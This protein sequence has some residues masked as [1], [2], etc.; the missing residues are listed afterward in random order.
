MQVATADMELRGSG[1]LLG[2]S[3]HGQIDAVGLDTYIELL[4]EAVGQARG[5][6]SRE[7][8]DPEVELPVKAIIPED[9]IDEIPARLGAYRELGACRTVD[10]VRHLID[11]WEAEWGEPPPEVLNLGWSAEARIRCRSLG[12]ERVTWMRVRVMLDFHPTTQ[13][14][15]S[16]VAALITRQPSRFSMS[17]AAHRTVRDAEPGHRLAVRFSPEEGQ[18]PYRFLHWVFR[19]LERE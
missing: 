9:Y 15:P 5:E 10:Q 18:T 19:Q 12:I 1:D 6:L 3:Q 13:V 4:D 11:R 16:R 7:R 17:D 2:D 8:L 14:P